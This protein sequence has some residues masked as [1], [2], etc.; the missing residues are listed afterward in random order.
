MKPRYAWILVLVGFVT[1]ASGQ[2]PTKAFTYQGSLREAGVPAEGLYDL[3]VTVHDAAMGGTQ[4]LFRV[5]DDVAVS[6]G[7]FT[8][9]IPD[10]AGV[11]DPGVF[12]GESRWIE[13]GVRPGASGSLDPFDV[14]SERQAISPT[15]YAIH[16][17]TQGFSR[18][19]SVDAGSGVIVGGTGDDRVLV[20]RAMPLTPAEFFGIDAPAF[21]FGGMYINTLTP[22]TSGIP[23]YGYA[24]DGS[25]LGWT[26]INA[27]T[28]NYSVVLGGVSRLTLSETGFLEV[29]TVQAASLSSFTSF[30]TTLSATLV[31]ADTVD[32]VLLDAETTTV[33][34]ANASVVNA[35]S[36]ISDDFRFTSARQRLNFIPAEAFRP[37]SS[38]EA[39]ESGLGFIRGI[40]GSTVVF[41]AAAE[42][43]EGAVINFIVIYADARFGASPAEP[44]AAR[45][46]EVGPPPFGTPPLQT[47]D[48]NLLSSA[49]SRVTTV[50]GSL[51]GVDIN[52]T[53]PPDKSF[54]VEIVSLSNTGPTGTLLPGPW[55]VE[56]T[57]FGAGIVYTVTGP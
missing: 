26:Q 10:R 55:T 35:G 32:A 16:S 44:L 28:G 3:R 25:V 12:T 52:Y 53:V 30:A 29:D 7:V 43:P 33:G 15:P 9:E 18:D 22:T 17:L 21:D 5:F 11:L 38:F 6:D 50:G 4:L 54:V 20:N 40:P 31:N 47:P 2:G 36:V 37:S 1:C 13:I 8:L 46:Y 19:E 56:Q 27:N 34:E 41:S 39:W 23:F 45:L 24:D 42:V 49:L 57:V 14:V 48:V 51:N